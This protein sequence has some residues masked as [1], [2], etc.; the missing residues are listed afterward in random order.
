MQ[1]PVQSGQDC[2]TQQ[3]HLAR[4]LHQRRSDPSMFWIVHA[5]QHATPLAL[6][7]LTTRKPCIKAAAH[8]PSSTQMKHPA[9]LQP[10]KHHRCCCRLAYPADVALS[11]PQ[12]SPLQLM[13]ST[14]HVSAPPGSAAD[15]V[16]SIAPPFNQLMA[17]LA[18]FTPV[19]PP[20]ARKRRTWLLHQVQRILPP[21]CICSDQPPQHFHQPSSIQQLL[22]ASHPIR[23]PGAAHTN[24]A[25]HCSR[26]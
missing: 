13:P 4:M 5:T 22:S 25:K 20:T 7:Q 8:L 11:N 14:R 10:P 1:Q 9:C 6:P 19:Q 24:Q 3:H 18:A 21:P 2:P 26:Y 16:A 17:P 23:Q 12:P 15:S